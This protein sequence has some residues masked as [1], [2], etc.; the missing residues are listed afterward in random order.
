M[1]PAEPVHPV[2]SALGSA[3]PAKRVTL[4]TR[5]APLPGISWSVGNK[6]SLENLEQCSLKVLE[7][8]GSPSLCLL[9]LMGEK[10]CTV[11]ELSEFLQAMAHTDVLQ[12]LSPPG[13]RAFFLTRG[14]RAPG[15]QGHGPPSLPGA[16]GPQASFLTGAPGPRASFLT[17]APGPQ[18]SFLTRGSRATGLL[19]YPGAPGPRASFLTG[20]PGPRA[21]FLTGAPG[22]RASFLTRGLQ[23]R[24]PPSLPGGS[25]AV[26]LLPYPGAPGPRASFLT[27]GLQGRGPPSLPGLQGRGPPSLPGGS[28]AAGLL[29]YRGSRATGLLPYP[30]APGPRASF[31]TR[32]L[33]GCGP[34]SLPGGS[35]AAGL[36]PYPGVQWA[37]ICPT[38]SKEAARAL[39]G[40]DGLKKTKS[41]QCWHWGPLGKRW[42][43]PYS[44]AF[45]ALG[46]RAP[47]Y[48]AYE[49]DM[50]SMWKPEPAPMDRVYEIPGLESITSVGKMYFMPG[51]PPLIFLPWDHG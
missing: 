22:P 29:P 40:S 34:P 46:F 35:R 49:W 42:L 11:T 26:G 23:G 13:L 6:N 32:G 5:V 47:R 7:P 48:G 24:G 25:R 8:E 18:A 9:K 19:P 36:L 30:G 43:A 50:R 15:L 20:A 1:G 12:L 28:R 45:G 10:G 3:A 39:K 16:P 37:I 33:Q 44:S 51:I 31:L 27:R 14:S 4:A 2:Y 17:G 41:V 38:G 21:S